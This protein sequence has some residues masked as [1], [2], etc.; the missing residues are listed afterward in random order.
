M[1]NYIIIFR[2]SG[3]VFFDENADGLIEA[4][5]HAEAKI[6][7]DGREYETAFRDDTNASLNVFSAPQGFPK[8]QR[9]DADAVDDVCAYEV[10]LKAA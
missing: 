9:H 2:N 10:P 6:G 5:Q 3:N 7:E 1:T 8:V 4:V